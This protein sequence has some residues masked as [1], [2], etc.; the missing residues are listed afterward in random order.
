M[1][2]G[3]NVS[4]ILSSNDSENFSFI[5]GNWSFEHIH[6][7]WKCFITGCS[8]KYDSTDFPNTL[9]EKNPPP[10]DF[11]EKNENENTKNSAPVM[12]GGGVNVTKSKKQRFSLKC[13]FTA[14]KCHFSN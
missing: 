8:K 3:E 1:G 11:S 14:R 6:N 5:V 13:S 4:K 2:R 7:S 10:K 12:G 9:E